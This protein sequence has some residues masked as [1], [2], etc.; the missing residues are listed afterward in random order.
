VP[1]QPLHPPVAPIFVENIAHEAA[2]TAAILQ[3]AEATFS[4]CGYA[5]ASMRE[6]AL[7]AGVSKSLLHYHFESKEQLFVDVQI[8]AYRRLSERVM[9]AVAE[10]SGS[11]ERGLVAFDAL[12]AALRDGNDLGVQAELWA[13]ATSDPRLRHHVARLREFFRALLAYSIDQILGEDRDRL[14]MGVEA[15]ADLI[16]AVLNGLGVAMAFAEPE[17]RVT[18]CIAAL[19]ILTSMTLSTSGLPAVRPKRNTKRRT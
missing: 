19:R 4:R 3:A 8:R 2:G 11:Q 7:A 9:A 1:S 5:G 18:R 14:P 13:S 10:V 6:I 16:W 17:E 12:F 15:A